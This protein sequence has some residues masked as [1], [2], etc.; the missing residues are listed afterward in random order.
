MPVPLHRKRL[1]ERGYN[2]SLELLRPV[3]NTCGLTVDSN[4][5]KR[6][7]ATDAQSSLP[8]KQRRIN[9][10]GAFSVTGEVK[11]KHIL[12]ADDVLTTGSTLNE[13]AKTLK[14]AGA[15]QVDAFVIART[16]Y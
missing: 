10:R 12:L 4:C 6:I 9:L 5:C 15:K 3:Q 1:A 7:R 13:L 14:G 8:A 11:G 2:Q 16:V